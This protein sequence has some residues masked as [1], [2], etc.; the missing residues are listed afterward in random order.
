MITRM[1]MDL[2]VRDK[3]A[4]RNAETLVKAGFNI[5]QHDNDN[6]SVVY[7]RDVSPDVREASRVLV[8]KRQIGY[9]SKDIPPRNKRRR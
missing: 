9:G 7:S 6:S 4:E 3:M 8:H 1:I 5:E 2:K